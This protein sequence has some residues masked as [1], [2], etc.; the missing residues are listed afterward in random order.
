MSGN[1]M[2][3]FT[4][5]LAHM[6]ERAQYDSI[7]MDLVNTEGPDTPTL[8][9]RTARNTNRTPARLGGTSALSAVNTPHQTVPNARI[10]RGPK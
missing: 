4:D 2:S 9:N 8:Q 3:G 1:R 7:N 10:L 6:D 5:M